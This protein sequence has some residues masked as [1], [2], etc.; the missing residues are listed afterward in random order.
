MAAKESLDDSFT[1]AAYLVEKELGVMLTPDYPALKFAV[2]LEEIQKDYKKQNDEMKRAKS[3][4]RG[5]SF[6]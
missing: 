5:N 2:Q 4:S 1:T 6:R 3:K